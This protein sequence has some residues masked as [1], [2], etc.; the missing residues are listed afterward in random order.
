[1]DFKRTRPYNQ[2]CRTVNKEARSP[3]HRRLLTS[4]ARNPNRWNTILAGGKPVDCSRD[5]LKTTNAEVETW[6][7]P[8][9][10]FI[11]SLG[12]PRTQIS[13]TAGL[14]PLTLS[15]IHLLTAGERV[16]NAP[17]LARQRQ[18]FDYSSPAMT[19]WPCRR[20]TDS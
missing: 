8:G 5:A 13:R 19:E 3:P 14:G 18:L 15:K 2:T 16:S 9:A 17:S 4:K 6:R 12:K 10:S 11:R 1:M 7:S 20:S